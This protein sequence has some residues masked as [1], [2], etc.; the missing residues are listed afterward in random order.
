M[1]RAV[2]EALGEEAWTAVFTTG[3]AL[4]MEQAIAYALG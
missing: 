1:D 3:L 4:A 2:A